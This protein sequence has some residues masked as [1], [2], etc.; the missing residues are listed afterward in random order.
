MLVMVDEVRGQIITLQSDG[1]QN[2]H[3]TMTNFLE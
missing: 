2:H 1:Y 3:Q